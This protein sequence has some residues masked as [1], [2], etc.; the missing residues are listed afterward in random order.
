MLLEVELEVAAPSRSSQA[1]DSTMS[2]FSGAC[3]SSVEDGYSKAF[4]SAGGRS[5]SSP[6][7]RHQ[8]TSVA[9]SHHCQSRTLPSG[10]RGGGSGP[11]NGPSGGESVSR[12]S[13]RSPFS[14]ACSST[15][16]LPLSPGTASRRKKGKAPRPPPVG[17]ETSPSLQT[18]TG[19][20]TSSM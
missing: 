5:S 18:T 6:C 17:D 14:V 12:G 10:D 15:S 11:K 4:S 20:S 2:A 3:D 19:K 13:R 8:C 16:S 1:A 9:S 7:Q